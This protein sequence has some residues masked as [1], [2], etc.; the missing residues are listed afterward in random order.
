MADKLIY[1]PNDDTQYFPL[2][3]YKKR[4]DT[5]T[6]KNSINVPKVVKPT[7]KNC[8]YKSMETSVI[9]SPMSLH[10]LRG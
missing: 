1:I 2:C 3:R 8:Y 4:L 5:Q 10:S 7:N 6:N 9:N